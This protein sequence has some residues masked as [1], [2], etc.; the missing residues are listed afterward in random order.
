MSGVTYVSVDVEA[1]GPCPG[2]YSMIQV[3][4]VVVEPGLE[5]TF[6]ANIAPISDQWVP[7]ALAVSGFTREQTWDFLDALTQMRKFYQWCA[8]LHGNERPNGRLLFVSDNA[9]FDW[10]FVNWYFHRYL[11]GNPF[12]FSPMSLT[13]L[14]K[15]FVKHTRR[16]FRR[17]G[18][19]TRKATRS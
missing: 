8:G 13:S 14:Y 10:Q 1:D 9:G 15:G 12:G 7:E 18:L 19:R 4:A 2:L 17:D 11:G 16:D 6:A 5:R 3:G